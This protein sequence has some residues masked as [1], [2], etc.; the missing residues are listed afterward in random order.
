MVEKKV[1]RAAS[2][3]KQLAIFAEKLVLKHKKFLMEEINSE[4]AD[5]LRKQYNYHNK[6]LE[7]D[8]ES[9]DKGL[10]RGMLNAYN[11]VYAKIIEIEKRENPFTDAHASWECAQEHAEIKYFHELEQE[12]ESLKKPLL[13]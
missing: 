12:L 9:L 7:H 11:E 13:K 3:F 10:R 5:Y 4:L 1:K 8:A 2:D 6:N